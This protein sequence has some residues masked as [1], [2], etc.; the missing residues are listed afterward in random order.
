MPGFPIPKPVF[1]QLYKV[2][3]S[4][5]SLE[6]LKSFYLHILIKAHIQILLVLTKCPFSVPG[7]FITFSCHISLHSFWLCEFPKLVFMALTILRST[8]QLFCKLALKWDFSDVSL[9]IR[10]GLW[11]WGRKTTKVKYPFITSYQGYML[12]SIGLSLRMLI[13]VI[14]WSQCLS[15]FSTVKSLFSLG[16]P[17][18]TL[19]KEAAM[20][21]PR[22][23]SGKYLHILFE[24]LLHVYSS[25]LCIYFFNHLFLSVMTNEYLVFRL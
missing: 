16:I 6:Q 9:M 11:V 15:D 17:Y 19:W 24:I 3:Q 12:L 13:L 1:F 2:R 5:I 23:R 4:K 18:S 21:N 20:H 8:C 14:W 10:L 25:N 7:H 22:L